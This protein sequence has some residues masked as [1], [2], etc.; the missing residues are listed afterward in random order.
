[1]LDP[2]LPFRS[3]PLQN[4]Q[5]IGEPSR[6]QRQA[7][8]KFGLFPALQLLGICRARFGDRGLYGISVDQCQLECPLV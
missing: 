6:V 2:V 3:D 1:M 5:G 7:G 8:Y 4:V